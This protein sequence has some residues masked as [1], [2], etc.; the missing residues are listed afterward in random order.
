MYNSHDL[1]QKSQAG[2]VLGQEE[3]LFLLNLPADSAESALVM[4][5]AARISKEL[6]KGKAEIHAQFAVNLAPCMGNCLF[7]SFA[8][9]NGVFHTATEISVEQARRQALQFETDGAN[10]IY[11][12]ATAH[13]SLEHFLER[14]QEVRHVLRPETVLIANVGDQSLSQAQRLK[15]AGFAGVYHAVR[16]GEGKD[17]GLD[18][19]QRRQS[20][21]TFQE[22][23]LAVGTCVEPVGPEHSNEELAAMIAFTASVN[24]AFSGAARR[25]SIPGTE[26]A[27]R[28][29]ISELRM[30]QIVAITRLGLPSSVL[31]NCT[32]EPCTLGAFAGANLFWAETGANPR[33]SKEKTEEGRGESVPSCASLFRE[34]HWELWSG[35]SRF[36]Y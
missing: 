18:P 29:M 23:G 3:L 16:L 12:M 28:G 6:N 33:D 4:A 31:G 36:F 1:I 8:Q 11:M 15:E 17:T 24:P 10:A 30:A 13:Y 5:E 19:E 22:A 14:A 32:H 26:L 2:E 35:P 34:T 7:C 27:R 25:I 9:K 21:R 20:I